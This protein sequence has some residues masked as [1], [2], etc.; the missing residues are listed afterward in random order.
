[1][2]FLI[3][4]GEHSDFLSAQPSFARQHGD[5]QS[6]PAFDFLCTRVHVCVC[7]CVCVC[8][9]VCMNHCLI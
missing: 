6:L 4:K 5:L 1:M 2:M 9:C 7:V 3:C 8:A